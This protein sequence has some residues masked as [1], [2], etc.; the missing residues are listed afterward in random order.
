[1]HMIGRVVFEVYESRA[2]VR[3]DDLAVNQRLD[4]E[5]ALGLRLRGDS[6]RTLLN[7]EF[8]Q[9]VA[10]VVGCQRIISNQR[11]S[12]STDW[13]ALLAFFLDLL[14]QHTHD[15]L[16]ELLIQC[17]LLRREGKGEHTAVGFTGL[18]SDIG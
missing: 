17:D 16:G 4:A 12:E 7:V 18:V 6:A 2:V 3:L 10:E 9:A 11:I 15:A 14:I 1:M 5:R 13:L 8:A